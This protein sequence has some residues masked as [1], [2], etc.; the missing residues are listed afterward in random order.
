MSM[1]RGLGAVLICALAVTLAT[2]LS[3]QTTQ[4]KETVPAGAA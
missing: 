2:S 4:K 3:A 1:T